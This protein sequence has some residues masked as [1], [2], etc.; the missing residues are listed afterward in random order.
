MENYNYAMNADI[1]TKLPNTN[2]TY[3]INMYIDTYCNIYID[4]CYEPYT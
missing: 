4:I 3:V 1:Y 2:T